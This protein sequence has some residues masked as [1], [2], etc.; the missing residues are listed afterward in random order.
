MAWINDKANNYR[1]IYEDIQIARENGFISTMSDVNKVIAKTLYS[2][3]FAEERIATDLQKICPNLDEIEIGTMAIATL[4]MNIIENKELKVNRST[5][6]AILKTYL[7]QCTEYDHDTITLL[8]GNE[9]KA[10]NWLRGFIVFL[11]DKDK[12]RGKLISEL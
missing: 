6:K 7:E 1:T 9:V 10:L 8:T 4:A 5:K 3:T 2:L 12:E 11:S